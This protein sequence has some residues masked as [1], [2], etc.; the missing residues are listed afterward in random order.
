MP[1][2]RVRVPSA[3]VCAGV[4]RVITDS[5]MN[6]PT[7]GPKTPDA[8]KYM[9]RLAELQTQFA[10]QSENMQVLCKHLMSSASVNTETAAAVD[11]CV[12]IER[13]DPLPPPTECD[14]A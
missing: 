1:C 5:Y 10:K 8:K 6:C 2:L 7:P 3:H 14:T 4:A 9:A 13:E 11:H 12:R